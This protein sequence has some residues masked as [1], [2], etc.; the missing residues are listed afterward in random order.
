MTPC[1]SPAS[2]LIIRY[3]RHDHLGGCPAF[4]QDQHLLDRIFEE[5]HHAMSRLKQRKAKLIEKIDAIQDE[6]MLDAVE[7]TLAG[8]SHYSLSPDQQDQ[9]QESLA[10]YLSGE[11]KTYSPE[12]AIT[13]AR[14]AA[15]G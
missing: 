7:K 4:A 13:K 14:K 3:W 1:V 5:H 8:S 12:E 10:R 11:A 9:L 6:H 2:G 15:R